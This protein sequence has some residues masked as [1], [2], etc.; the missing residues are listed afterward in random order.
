MYLFLHSGGFMNRLLSFLLATMLMFSASACSGK[1]PLE[2]AG[3]QGKNIISVLNDI[4]RAYEKKDLD[5]FLSNVS[6][7]YKDRDSL[8]TSLATVFAKYDSIR[9]NIQ[10]TKMVIMAQESGKS[11]TSCNWDAEWVAPGGTSQKSG[12][13]VTLVFDSK[14]FKLLAIEGKNPFIP[15]ESTPRQ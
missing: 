9:F 1:K 4:T 7:E 8:A 12:G 3:L 13:R 6:D 2:S 11:K 10:H 14:K 15:T 5:A